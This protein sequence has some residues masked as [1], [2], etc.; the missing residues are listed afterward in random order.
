MGRQRKKRKRRKERSDQ[1]AQ[2]QVPQPQAPKVRLSSLASCPLCREPV[3]SQAPGDLASVSCGGCSVSYHQECVKELGGCAT[4]GCSRRGRLPATLSPGPAQPP[5]IVARQSRRAQAPRPAAPQTNP[6]G[7]ALSAAVSG[8]AFA[9]PVAFAVFLYKG[10]WASTGLDLLGGFRIGAKVGA[11]IW[12]SVVLFTFWTG[13][14]RVRD[15][16]G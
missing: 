2:E 14:A 12:V 4:L 9:L 1:E 7:S 13:P 3:G 6:E 10:V 8:L 16:A 5:R 11:G 15:W